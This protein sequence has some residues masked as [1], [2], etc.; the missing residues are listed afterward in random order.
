MYTGLDA[1]EKE[2]FERINFIQRCK[3]LY[4]N[5]NDYNDRLIN[6]D[7]TEVEEIIKSFG[8]TNV[9]YFKSENFFEIDEA[10]KEGLYEI[11]LNA[12][13]GI[14]LCEFIWDGAPWLRYLKLLGADFTNIKKPAFHSY[15]ELREILTV[16]FEMYEDYKR[17]LIAIYEASAGE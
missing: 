13:F 10:V 8:Y 17:E 9:K 1:Q 7:N 6:Y 15:N 4:D 5:H 2:A 12:S 14:G 16:A 3:D 11:S